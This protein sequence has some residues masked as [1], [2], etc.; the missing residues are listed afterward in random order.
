M[1]VMGKVST[2][3]RFNLLLTQIDGQAA[4]QVPRKKEWVRGRGGGKKKTA[5]SA[6][7]WSL[8]ITHNHFAVTS[9]RNVDASATMYS[10]LVLSPSRNPES[11]G[12]A[13]IKT[14]RLL[15][16]IEA[17]EARRRLSRGTRGNRTPVGFNSHSRNSREFLLAKLSSRPVNISDN[18]NVTRR[19]S[20]STRRIRASAY[21]R[22]RARNST[23]LEIPA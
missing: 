21:A 16:T 18:E 8:V 14:L 10:G 12:R 2:C 11:H 17:T 3:A 1:S 20:V 5:R 6:C 15:A 7:R 23:S 9:R 19:Y 13:N 4:R 22:A